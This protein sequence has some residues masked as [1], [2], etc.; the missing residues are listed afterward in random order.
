MRAKK[1]K[2]PT[3]NKDGGLTE[4]YGY[5]AECGKVITLRNQDGMLRKHGR[6]VITGSWCLGSNMLPSKAIAEA[7]SNLKKTEWT[8]ARRSA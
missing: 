6:D 4:A 5:C 1:M 7:M 8:P 2:A 3:M